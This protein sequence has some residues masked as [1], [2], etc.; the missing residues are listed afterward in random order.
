MQYANP[1]GISENYRLNALLHLRETSVNF[2]SNLH[3][4]IGTAVLT[5]V[6]TLAHSR[7][8]RANIGLREPPSCKYTTLLSEV[9]GHT[10]EKPI[11]PMGPTIYQAAHCLPL[12]HHSP[13]RH[14]CEP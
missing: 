1:I 6:Y 11:N 8:L 2:V 10:S 13:L 4:E 7:I 5:L 9:T 12:V 3:E 14:A